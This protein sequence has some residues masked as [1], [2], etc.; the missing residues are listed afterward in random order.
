MMNYLFYKSQI[1]KGNN[2]LKNHVLIWE[3]ENIIEK[4]IF[5]KKN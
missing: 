3:L 5:F 2:S 4:N 1:V